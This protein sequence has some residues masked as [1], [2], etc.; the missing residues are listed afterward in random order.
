MGHAVLY[1]LLILLFELG[2]G[3]PSV[4]IEPV[5]YPTI[6]FFLLSL[7]L[8]KI[9]IEIELFHDQDQESSLGSFLIKRVLNTNKELLNSFL[10][11]N[12][13]I[14]IKNCGG[15]IKLSKIFYL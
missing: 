3:L 8:T 5:L 11:R 10:E 6:A 1:T 7:P 13:A 2:H 9:S 14:E 4:F 15:K 12:Y